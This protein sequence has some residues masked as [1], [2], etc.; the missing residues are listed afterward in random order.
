MDKTARGLVLL[1]TIVIMVQFWY[2]TRLNESM[3]VIEQAICIQ[4]ATN[5]EQNRI[6]FSIL[7]SIQGHGLYDTEAT[8]LDSVI[9]SWKE[10][11]K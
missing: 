11:G 4:D 10:E 6:L 9:A 3:E 1:L 8:N 5:G 7:G 2:L